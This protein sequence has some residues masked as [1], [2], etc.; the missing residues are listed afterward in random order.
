ML[1]NLKTRTATNAKI[2]GFL[3]CVEVIIYYSVLDNLHDCT[4]NQRFRTLTLLVPIQ[5]EEKKLSSIFILTLLCSASKGFM[6][7]LKAFLKPT[8]APQNSVKIKI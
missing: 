4:F 3:I 1:N 2:S 5:G 6:K 7:A 8:V